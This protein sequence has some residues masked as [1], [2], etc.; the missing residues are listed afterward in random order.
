MMSRA[1]APCGNKTGALRELP[2]LEAN[3]LYPFQENIIF[4]LTTNN[5][6]GYQ[7]ISADL[8]EQLAGA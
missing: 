3:S 5:L 7:S 6:E 8:S 1:V 4:S 2:K